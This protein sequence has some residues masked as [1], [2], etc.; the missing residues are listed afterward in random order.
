MSILKLFQIS[1]NKTDKNVKSNLNNNKKLFNEMKKHAKNIDIAII[2]TGPD[3][4]WFSFELY[5]KT[6]ER[7][8][9]NKEDYPDYIYRKSLEVSEEY[10]LLKK[11]N[12]AS[13]N[14][15]IKNY[16]FEE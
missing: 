2:E 8:L 12:Q 15:N 7:I 6:R 13:K 10:L 4:R 5:L 3:G 16:P 14:N 1:R 9:K 11:M